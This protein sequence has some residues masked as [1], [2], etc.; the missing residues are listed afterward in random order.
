MM[1][2]EKWS[3]TAPSNIALIKY[4]GK[5]DVSLNLPDNPSLSY[6]LP[7]L[8]T[9]VEIEKSDLDEDVWEPLVEDG[10]FKLSLGPK[11]STRYLK[12]FSFLK[13]KFEITGSFKVRSAN[14]FPENCGLASS[15]SSFAALTKAASIAFCEILERELISPVEMAGLSRLG[16][17]SSCRSFI[18]PWCVWSDETVFKMDFPYKKLIHMVVMS[19]GERKKVSSSQAHKNVQSSLLYESREERATLRMGLLTQALGKQNWTQVYELCWAEFWDMHALFETSNPSFGYMNEGTFSV[20]RFAKSIWRQIGDGP[21][22][23]MDAGPNVHLLFRPE[24]L[25]M[26]LS[27][28]EKCKALNLKVFSQGV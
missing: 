12:H 7:H 3:A 5:K 2:R 8:I 10:F 22:V 20:L 9:K 4:M 25:E 26:A 1:K 17:G 14:N 21:I 18:E 15:A 6:T 19:D 13:E 11:E 28:K 23:T 24:Q 27:L 16:S